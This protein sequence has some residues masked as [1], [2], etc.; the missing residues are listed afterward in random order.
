[1]T[2]VEGGGFK[3]GLILTNDL[4]KRFLLLSSLA[5]GTSRIGKECFA[6]YQDNVTKWE[7]GYDTDGL[8]SQ[9]GSTILP[10]L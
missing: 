6:Q 4:P 3:P 2:D 5:L 9:P 8:A 1:M 10:S 7:L